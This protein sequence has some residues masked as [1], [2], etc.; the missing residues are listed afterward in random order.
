MT[1]VIWKEKHDVHV[2]TN[3]H[4]PAEGNFCDESG[5]PLKSAIVED[6]NQHMGYVNKSDICEQ[7]LY[8]SPMWKWTKNCSFLS[9]TSLFLTATFS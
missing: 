2:L 7:L 9:L 4:D 5:N 8:Q 1:A 6:C 3:I